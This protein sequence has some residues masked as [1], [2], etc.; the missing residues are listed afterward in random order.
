[1]KILIADDD[2]LWQR[3]AQVTLTRSGYEVSLVSNG[4]AAWDAL[5]QPDAPLLALL[6]WMMPGMDGIDVCR[7]LRQLSPSPLIYVILL[8]ALDEEEAVAQAVEAGADD[9]L[10]KPFS[11]EH[12]RLRVRVGMRVLSLEAV[13]QRSQQELADIHAHLNRVHQLLPLCP[14]CRWRRRSRR[15]WQQIQD[16]IQE[17]PKERIALSLCPRCQHEVGGHEGKAEAVP[18][19]TVVPR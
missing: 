3:L 4:R 17:Q 5:Q 18:V 2:P 9:Y 6:D 15:Y 19:I 12:L 7:R 10:I 13:R 14:R 11:P 16:Y 8:T 1:M